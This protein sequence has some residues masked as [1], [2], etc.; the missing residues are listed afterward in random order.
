MTIIFCVACPDCGSTSALKIVDGEPTRADIEEVSEN[1]GGY[2][3][4]EF[5]FKDVEPGKIYEGGIM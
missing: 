4:T 1:A 2:C 3:V 5:I